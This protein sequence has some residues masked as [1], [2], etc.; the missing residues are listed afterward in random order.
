MGET[1]VSVVPEAVT[2][3][4]K[5]GLNGIGSAMTDI[6]GTVLPIALPIA[7][8]VMAVRFGFRFFRSVTAA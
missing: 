2:T 5:T 8:V 1:A 6:I 7:G 4:L 3:A